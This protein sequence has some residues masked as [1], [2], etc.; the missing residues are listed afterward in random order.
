M[1]A[2]SEAQSEDARWTSAMVPEEI[3]D[4]ADPSDTQQKADLLALALAASSARRNRLTAGNVCGNSADVWD[5]V[6]AHMNEDDEDLQDCQAMRWRDSFRGIRVCTF[7]QQKTWYRTQ[8][9]SWV[10]LRVL[11]W[12]VCQVQNAT[13]DWGCALHARRVSQAPSERCWSQ[14]LLRRRALDPS[15]NIISQKSFLTNPDERP[16]NEGRTGSVEQWEKKHPGIQK[17]IW[18]AV[19]W[20]WLHEGSLPRY[21]V[22]EERRS[23]MI[24]FH[25]VWIIALLGR[26]P[27]NFRIAAN[28]RVVTKEKLTTKTSKKNRPREKAQADKDSVSLTETFHSACEAEKQR[29]MSQ[30]RWR[31]AA[32]KQM[33][34]AAAKK[35]QEEKRKVRSKSMTQAAAAPKRKIR[36]VNRRM[37]KTL[38]SSC[39]KRIRDHWIQVTKYKNWF[40]RL[41][42][43]DGTLFCFPRHG[44][45]RKLRCGS[46]NKD[47]CAG[48]FEKQTRSGEKRSSGPNTSTNVPLQ[49]RSQSTN[50]GSH[51]WVCTF[52]LGIRGPTR[53]KKCSTQLRRWR[54]PQKT[55]KLWEETSTLNFVPELKLNASVLECIPSTNQT[56]EVTG[57]SSSW[58]DTKLWHST[59]CTK[60]HLRNK[61]HTGHLKVQ[62]SSWTTSWWT[63]NTW[64]AVKTLKQTTWYTWEVITDALWR[65]MWFQHQK[66]LPKPLLRGKTLWRRASKTR[67]VKK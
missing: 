40:M 66:R 44:D 64:D 25:M 37:N 42:I 31:A 35:E 8:Y 39:Y 38:L 12:V 3:L 5:T 7:S 2:Y 11:S 53:P 34:D 10:L 21:L 46:R 30:R 36:N 63:E 50:S 4:W 1:W 56:A 16:H 24:L 41:K 14:H 47:T 22:G 33:K 49:H 6:S 29:P 61:L 19:S 13:S 52:P 67:R 20:G 51:C 32:K 9:K 59:R 55:C 60:K 62:R 23:R 57:W 28:L 15:L 27:R 54:N 17:S 45:R 26:H 18:T 65:S 58:C 43:A 48:K